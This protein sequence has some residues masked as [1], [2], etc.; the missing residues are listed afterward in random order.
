MLEGYNINPQALIFTLLSEVLFI[1]LVC[2]LGVKSGK[3]DLHSAIYYYRSSA[4][5]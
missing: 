3:P 4:E 2:F 1:G 5:I